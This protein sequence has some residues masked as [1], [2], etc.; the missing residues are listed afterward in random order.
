MT[1]ITTCQ[2]KLKQNM[3]KGM[4]KNHLG[5]LFCKSGG[6]IMA[7]L[8]LIDTLFHFRRKKQV[9]N[10]DQMSSTSLDMQYQKQQVLHIPRFNK[11]TVRKILYMFCQFF[12][13]YESRDVILCARNMKCLCLWTFQGKKKKN[14]STPVK[15]FLWSFVNYRE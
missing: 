9:S 3:F 2:V 15:L 5:F 12:L 7:G 10:G 11:A 1:I 4:E 13:S 6:N 14:C 8:I